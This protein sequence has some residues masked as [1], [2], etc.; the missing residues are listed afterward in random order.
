ML[1]E[2]LSDWDPSATSDVEYG[3]T[4]SESTCKHCQLR[5]SLRPT[6][7]RVGA[8]TEI[9]ASLYEHLV[10]DRE[11]VRRFQPLGPLVTKH[12]VWLKPTIASNGTTGRP[13][14]RRPRP[15]SIRPDGYRRGDMLTRPYW[16]S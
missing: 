11:I 7:F 2:S 3:R 5:I 12:R 16:P 1:Y 14:R 15:R 10:V 4:T 6:N 8:S 9:I 13:H